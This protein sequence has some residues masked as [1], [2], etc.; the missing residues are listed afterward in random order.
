MGRLYYPLSNQD[1]CLPFNIEADFPR[2]FLADE[3][4]DLT[5]VILVDRGNCTFVTKARNIERA[6]VH[7]AIV[8]DNQRENS[9]SIIMGD[10]GTGSSVNIPSFLIRKRDADKIKEQLASKNASSVYIKAQLDMAH[11]DNRVEYEFWYSTVLDT[12]AWLMYD[13]SLYQ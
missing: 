7:L 5:P 3:K 10:D 9:E 1:G 4:S 13:I 12:E 2:E 11:P 8:G 6:G